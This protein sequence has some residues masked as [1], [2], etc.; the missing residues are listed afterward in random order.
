MCYCA[1]SCVYDTESHRTGIES[2]DSHSAMAAGCS[3]LLCTVSLAQNLVDLESITPFSALKVAYNSL[4][5]ADV[6]YTV[7]SITQTG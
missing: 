3:T 7:A 1:G 5:S 4:E 6:V 2:A